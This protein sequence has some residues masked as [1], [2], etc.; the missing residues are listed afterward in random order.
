[1]PQN[2]VNSPVFCLQRFSSIFETIIQYIPINDASF[3]LSVDTESRINELS[4]VF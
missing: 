4:E 3:E 1:M 2:K